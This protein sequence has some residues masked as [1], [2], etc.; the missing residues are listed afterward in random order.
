MEVELYR[1]DCLRV[2]GDIIIELEDK[3]KP[4]VFVSESP[5]KGED[6]Y[7][8]MSNKQYHAILEMIFVSDK[9]PSVVICYPNQMYCAVNSGVVPT[10]VTPWVYRDI[11]CFGIT[12]DF[13]QWDVNDGE[14]SVDVMKNIIG[15]L[16]EEYTVVDPFMGSGTTGV[17]AVELGRDFIG[18]EIDPVRFDNAEQRIFDA[19]YSL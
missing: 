7:R 18:V 14:M 3:N 13:K 10:K 1:N 15:A 2:L 12:P 4:F 8:E 11:V 5:Y 6:C 19:K 17:A 16:P 9:Y